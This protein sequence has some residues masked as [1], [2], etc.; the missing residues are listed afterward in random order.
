M[1]DQAEGTI[2]EV[3]SLERPFS[4]FDFV[5]DRFS[6]STPIRNLFSM[7]RA[8]EGK[9]LVLETVPPTG[10]VAEENADLEGQDNEFRSLAVMRVSFWD[11]VFTEGDALP[12][13]GC[14][15]YALLKHDC[16]AKQGRIA[17]FIYE[18]V[19]GINQHSHNFMNASADFEFLCCDTEV[20]LSLIHI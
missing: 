13:S 7:S 10:G 12:E 16:L 1:S 3:H 14:L 20:S 11:S 19:F 5:E 17:W 4:A 8:R 15:G 18:A 9:T 6:G 2:C